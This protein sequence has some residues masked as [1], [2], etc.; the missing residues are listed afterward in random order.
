MSPGPPKPFVAIAFAAALTLGCTL[1]AG[2]PSAPSTPPDV[3]PPSCPD[4]SPV[5]CPADKEYA[6]GCWGADTSCST[7]YTDNDGVWNACI[8]GQSAST[9]ESGATTCCAST[10]PV[11]CDATSDLSD[12]CFAADADCNT[13]S[14]CGEET[15]ICPSGLVV[16]CDGSQSGCCP[17]ESP[18]WCANHDGEDGFCAAPEADCNQ[19]AECAQ[20]TIV[21]SQGETSHCDAGGQALCCSIASGTWCAPASGGQTD[22]PGRCMPAN[23]SCATI[24]PKNDDWTACKTTDIVGTSSTGETLCC[25][26]ETPVWCAPGTYQ[27]DT[28]F[29]GD[30]CFP[31]TVDCSTLFWNEADA[32]WDYCNSDSVSV[33]IDASGQLVCCGGETPV[34]CPVGT[35]L[36]LDFDGSVC[37]ANDTNCASAFLENGQWSA[38]AITD[39]DFGIAAGKDGATILQCCGGGTPQYCE[40]GS[41]DG[42]FDGSTCFPED[43]NCQSIVQTAPDTWEA[44]PS[45]VDWA[46]SSQ[47]VLKCC[48]NSYETAN[49]DTSGNV[50]CCGAPPLGVALGT[51]WCPPAMIWDGDAAYAYANDKW[52][53]NPQCEGECVANT[54]CSYVAENPITGKDSTFFA[55]CSATPVSCKQCLVPQDID[56]AQNGGLG[57]PG[58]LTFAAE[59]PGACIIDLGVECSRLMRCGGQISPCVHDD[60][61]CWD[62]EITPLL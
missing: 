32:Q 3:P 22:F 9:S 48:Q 38:C 49:K 43:T 47:G 29:P 45:N 44:C 21:C 28:A 50:Y 60:C 2:N 33:G 35:G 30:R 46:V 27:G 6:G 54:D 39:A 53:S 1:G 58:K 13:R 7:L 11:Y 19:T 18:T 16:A 23:T 41:G 37:L 62:G 4:E 15:A 17:A 8:V 25:G 10:T 31:S 42:T 57:A 40:V 20:G 34:L 56:V 26:G 55:S 51:H 52:N 36:L 61:Y 5:Y 12:G 24:T 59:F 14:L